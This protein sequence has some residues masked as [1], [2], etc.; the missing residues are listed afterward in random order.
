M[1]GSDFFNWRFSWELGKFLSIRKRNWIFSLWSLLWHYALFL[2]A[3]SCNTCPLLCHLLSVKQFCEKISSRA[4]FLII[5][6]L[7]APVSQIYSWD[8]TLHV[9]DNSSVH[10][11]EF[12]TV[13]TAVVCHTGL[14]CVQWKTSDDGHWNCLKHVEFQSKN[15]FEKLVHLVSLL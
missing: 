14:L 10:H 4:I 3:L 7:D 13:H 11:Q 12:F 2:N 6:Q 1:C 9:S 8:E 5:N 15:K